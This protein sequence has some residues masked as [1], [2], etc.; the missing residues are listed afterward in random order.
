MTEIRDPE[1]K[2]G[3]KVNANGR[4]LVQSAAP[5]DL[6]DAVLAGE[7]YMITVA[8]V[9]PVAAGDYYL[10]LANISDDPIQITLIELEDAG[11]ETHLG[12]VSANYAGASTAAAAFLVPNRLYGST[13]VYSTKAEIQCDTDMTGQPGTILE[14]FR[15]DLA[16][17]TLT[18]FELDK[19]P[20]MLLR[21]QAFSLQ[22]VTGGTAVTTV[23]ISYHH[24]MEPRDN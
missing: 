2:T 24:V 15:R 7:A 10:R 11:A 1:K 8:T 3:Q 13:N 17:T 4:G 6:A 21:N 14:V 18:R 20:I 5:G 12:M 23:K 16:A 9:T 22:A 19:D